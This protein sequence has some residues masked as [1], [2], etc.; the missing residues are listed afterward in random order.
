MTIKYYNV[1]LIMGY[2]F[3]FL[4]WIAFFMA[5]YTNNYPPHIMYSV[6]LLRIIGS[7]LVYFG[8]QASDR[9]QRAQ[10]DDRLREK[11]K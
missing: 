11:Y 5:L 7:V 4:G 9:E 3:A 1:I 10:W 2:C 8:R 6:A